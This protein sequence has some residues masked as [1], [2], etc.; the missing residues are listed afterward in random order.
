MLTNTASFFP[1]CAGPLQMS[2][3]T[4]EIK[5]IPIKTSLR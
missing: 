4:P 5:N 3:K 2:K 1:A